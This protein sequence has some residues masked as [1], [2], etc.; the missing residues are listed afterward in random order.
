MQTL[1]EVYENY[2]APEGWGDKGTLHSYIDLY[3]EHMTRRSGISILEIGVSHGHSIAMWQDYFKNSRVY[4]IDI[5]LDKIMFDLGNVYVGD[6]TSKTVIDDFFKKV[7][8]DYVVDDGS[9]V[10]EDQIA[11]FD[12]LAPKMKKGGKYFIEDVNG[13]KAINRI[14]SHLSDNGYDFEVFDLRHIKGR[15]DDVVIMVRM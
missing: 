11:S 15:Y 2:S 3:Q 14:V 6:A 8:F 5:T 9:H 7:K 12:A 4:G 10:I 1:Q 13:D